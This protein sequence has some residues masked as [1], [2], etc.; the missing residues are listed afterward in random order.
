MPA[1]AAIALSVSP[2]CTTYEQPAVLLAE[3]GTAVAVEPVSSASASPSPDVTLETTGALTP[4]SCWGG[5]CTVEPATSPASGERPFAAASWSTVRPSA[6]AIEES[7]S[8]GATTWT[9]NAEAA[10]GSTRSIPATTPMSR[11][12][13]KRMRRSVVKTSPDRNHC[14]YP[15]TLQIRLHRFEAGRNR[16]AAA[17]LGR[18]GGHQRPGGQDHPPLRTGVGLTQRGDPLLEGPALGLRQAIVRLGE[19]AR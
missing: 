16:G 7:D 5:I 19:R 17:T 4:G 3:A 2:G 15:F 14:K 12:N 6:A 1:R 10:A 8:P 13:R 11:R 18:G 9:K